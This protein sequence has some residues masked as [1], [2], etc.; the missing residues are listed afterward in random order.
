MV[1]C[2][3]TRLFFQKE[4]PTITGRIA[5]QAG[6][7]TWTDQSRLQ[8]LCEEFLALYPNRG[9]SIVK[10]V[11][12]SS[13]VTV[14]KF[15][16]LT[17][18]EIIDAISKSTNHYRGARWGQR[19]NMVVLDIDAGSRYHNIE[20]LAKLTETLRN[21]GVGKTRLYQ[22]SDSG[23]WHLYAFLYKSEATDEVNRLIKW[24]L[25]D[26]GFEIRGGTLEIFPSGNALRL[27]LQPGFAW[28]D[29]QGGPI[30]S[31]QDLTLAE[32][33]GY[34]LSDSHNYANDWNQIRESIE[35]RMAE[36]STDLSR[37]TFEMHQFDQMVLDATRQLDSERWEKGRQYWFDGLTSQNQRHEA[38]L[39]VGYY[40]WF[41]DRQRG[42]SPLP[43]R[44][45]A[46]QR[47]RLI[48]D[49]LARK[50]NGFCRHIVAGKWE[51]VEADI[52]RAVYWRRDQAAQERVPYLVTERLVE[53]QMET[54]LTVEQLQ[55]ANQKR[56]AASREKISK[57]V[58][59]LLSEGK[60]VS[61]RAVERVTGCSRNTIRR[62]R[63]ILLSKG[64]GDLS[65]GGA[66]DSVAGGPESG[67]NDNLLAFPVPESSGSSETLVVSAAAGSERSSVR[68]LVLFPD[69][70]NGFK[71][72]NSR[73]V[74][75]GSIVSGRAPP[76]A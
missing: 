17:D 19:T 39:F 37:Q 10:H 22:S 4:S 21:V 69:L 8:S 11:R 63:D 53:R 71:L 35:L 23:G 62:H 65:P 44:R 24:C 67:A 5:V 25:V 18:T 16:Q 38:I 73:P 27:P 42:L 58:D 2:R 52:R 64:S 55:L 20:G 46:A 40:L 31:R 32:A 61:I 57:G 14:S 9:Q 49:W 3:S 72:S 43:G 47:E 68:Q 54:F 74:D 75:L 51:K 56:E 29:L 12:S 76:G 60:N 15:H 28:L 13:W 26:A 41:G 30:L 48:R 66:E 33:L 34:F 36:Q 50:H 7:S 59:D 1:R 45:N 6:L 70:R